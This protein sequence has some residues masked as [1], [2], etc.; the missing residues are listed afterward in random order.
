MIQSKSR[1]AKTSAKNP[2]ERWNMPL[3]ETSVGR[4]ATELSELGHVASGEIGI[5]P[6][7]M[8]ALFQGHP[9]G[10]AVVTADPGSGPVGMT[11]SS[12]PFRIYSVR[13]FTRDVASNLGVSVPTLYRWIPAERSV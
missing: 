13:K 7:E 12:R 8:R 3:N 1:T 9:A 2:G 6:D 4:E 10:V 11:A 5:T